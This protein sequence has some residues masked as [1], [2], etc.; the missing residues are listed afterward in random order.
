MNRAVGDDKWGVK[1]NKQTI[2]YGGKL[3]RDLLENEEYILLNNLDI[4]E[5]GPWTWV[6]RSDP[7][8]RSC[9]DLAIVSRSLLP[10]VYKVVVDKDRDFTE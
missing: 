3:V 9:L 5:G 2:S 10:F 4:V 8:V 6:S 7:R 1:G